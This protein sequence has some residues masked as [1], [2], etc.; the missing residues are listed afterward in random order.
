MQEYFIIDQNNGSVYIN[1][2]PDREVA[3][4]ITL[5]IQVEDVNATDHKP[6]LADGM[7]IYLS[8]LCNNI[9]NL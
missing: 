9:K 8:Q 2:P 6:Q 5:K 7:D 3:K 1:E 4:T